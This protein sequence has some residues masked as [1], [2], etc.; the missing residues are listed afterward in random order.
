MFRSWDEYV[1]PSQQPTSSRTACVRSDAK[2][3]TEYQW[4]TTLKN[5]PAR[6]VIKEGENTSNEH[7]TRSSHPPLHNRWP[8]S[9]R[10]CRILRINQRPGFRQRRPRVLGPHSVGTDTLD[11]SRSRTP[12]KS[13]A[14]RSPDGSAASAGA[15]AG[16]DRASPH[17]RLPAR[18]GLILILPAC[19]HA[20]LVSQ[21][22]APEPQTGAVV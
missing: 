10:L 17:R 9:R 15:R 13:F 3:A 8:R 12:G 1:S 2:N 20:G 22:P 11:R 14:A 5:L 4:L 7:E 19:L 16:R 21:P 18:G 6:C